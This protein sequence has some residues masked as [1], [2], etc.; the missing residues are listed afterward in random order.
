[1]HTGKG[2]NSRL[3][4]IKQSVRPKALPGE[5]LAGLK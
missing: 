1:M 3:G 5:S 4:G 2:F